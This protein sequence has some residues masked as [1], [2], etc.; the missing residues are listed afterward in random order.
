MF[1]G[2][3]RVAAGNANPALFPT[4]DLT[5]GGGVVM[6]IDVTGQVFTSTDGGLSWTQKTSIPLLS[7]I[8]NTLIYNNGAWLVTGN[9]SNNFNRS[10][11]NG[12]TWTQPLTPASGNLWLG[13]DGATGVIALTGTKAYELSADNGQTFGAQ[14]IIAAGIPYKP[15]WDGA[16]WVAIG[17][18]NVSVSSIMTSPAVINWTATNIVPGTAAFTGSGPPLYDGAN[19]YAP[20]LNTSNAPCIRAAAT[21]AGLTVAADNAVPALAS[22]DISAIFKK[23]ATFYLVGTVG[24][25][26]YVYSTTTPTVGGSWTVVQALPG[27]CAAGCVDTAHNKLILGGS[28][29]SGAGYVVV[30]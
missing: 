16:Q 22:G 27:G 19:Y 1:L 13:G 3:A 12:A 10:A 11:N 18:D 17:I 5:F 8:A 9:S 28:L 29:F 15:L 20:T 24:G 14:Q 30:I 23:G 2:G 6:L 25:V 26:T 4:N 21:A 7:A